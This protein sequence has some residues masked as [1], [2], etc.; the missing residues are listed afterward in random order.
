[1]GQVENMKWLSKA[2]VEAELISKI[3]VPQNVVMYLHAMAIHK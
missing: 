1:M 2:G 3:E